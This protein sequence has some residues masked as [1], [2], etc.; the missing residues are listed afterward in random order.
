MVAVGAYFTQQTV[1]IGGLF[2][3]AFGWAFWYLGWIDAWGAVGFMGLI[4][5]TLFSIIGILRKRQR[6]VGV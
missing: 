3:C 6:E 1:E 4:I 5:G 2:M